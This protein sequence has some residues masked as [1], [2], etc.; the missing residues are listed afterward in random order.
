MNTTT[1]RISL[2]AM[3]LLMLVTGIYV[4]FRNAEAA[5]TYNN[6][7]TASINCN[8]DNSGNLLAL[9]AATGIKGKTTR[10]QVE[11]YVEK[12]VMG[13]FW[14][15]VDIGYTNNVWIDST[16]NTTYNNSFSTNLDTSGTFRVTVTFTVSGSG[17]SDDIIVKTAILSY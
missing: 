5:T 14:S 11:L 1:K 10:I 8:I 6:T 16:T 13:I 2:L 3:A 17:G 4:P 15:R 9:M 7:A 12:R